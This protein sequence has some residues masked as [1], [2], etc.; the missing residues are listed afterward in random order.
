[1]GEISVRHPQTQGQM[2][3]QGLTASRLSGENRLDQKHPVLPGGCERH[4]QCSSESG[5]GPSSPP[6]PLAEP[7]PPSPRRHLPLMSPEGQ[8]QS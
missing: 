7:F 4:L 2:L 1:M 3:M 6:S 8:G 5:Q